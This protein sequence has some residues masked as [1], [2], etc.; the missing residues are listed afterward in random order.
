MFYFCNFLGQ[1]MKGCDSKG[2]KSI[3]ISDDLDSLVQ[4]AKCFQVFNKDDSVSLH[5][6]SASETHSGVEM[7]FLG[8]LSSDK[9][10]CTDKELES[11]DDN[12]IIIVAT[13][14][15]EVYGGIPSYIKYFPVE[16]GVLVAL[17]K[18]FI[19]VE[20]KEGEMIPLSRNC[21]ASV[22]N[23]KYVY[24]ADYIKRLN[25]L[26]EKESGLGFS[27]YTVSDCIINH[28]VSKDGSVLKS[29][30]FNKDNF[31][32]LNKEVFLKA[33]ARKIEREELLKKEKERRAKEIAEF[34][35][36]YKRRMLEEEE[37][38]A[39]EKEK[40]KKQRSKKVVETEIAVDSEG[41]RS[42]LECVANLSNGR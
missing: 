3:S 37:R 25:I 6:I 31:N 2:V 21:E 15:F 11:T 22:P 34:N 8:N 4:T 26:E 16:G 13:K 28:T 1:E 41:A 29:V 35:A 36:N 5:F 14:S 40:P 7:D 12:P 42:F 33:K 9:V 17:I 23:N 38:K 24:S 27:S 32:I 20:S 18:G 39:K 19:S 30:K 10:K